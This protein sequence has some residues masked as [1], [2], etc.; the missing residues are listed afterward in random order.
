MKPLRL[1]FESGDL[2]FW[3]A[4]G[5][6]FANQPVRGDRL[7]ASRVRPELV[8][9]GGDYWDGPYPVGHQG[10]Y[11][12]GTE[13]HLTGTLTSDEFVINENYP[14]FNF[15]IGGGHDS[16]HLRVELL[17]KATAENQLA[18]KAGPASAASYP[19][20]SLPGK[21]DFYRVFEATG[22]DSEVMRRVT[23][24]VVDTGLTNQSARI[25]IVDNSTTHHINTDDFNFSPDC[26]Q[27]AP[28]AEGGGDPSAPV[29]GIADLH[30]HPMAAL[31]LGGL[32]FW[33]QPDGP[34]ETALR[35]CTPAHGI[36]GTGLQPKKGGSN[37][38]IAF[39]EGT[40]YQPG[41]RNWLHPGHPVGGYPYFDGWPRFT[42]IIHQQ[43]SI[44]WLR[45]TYEG[46][47]RL[48]VAHVVNN[49]L[50]AHEF[51]S[52]QSKLSHNDKTAVE[53]QITAMK[54]LAARHA[55]WMEI[56]YSPAA[57][58]RII[59]QNK[60]AVVL[61][62]EVDSLGSWNREGDCTEDDVR[63]YL[64]HLYHDLGVR[65]LFPIH[66]AN[67]AF[68]GAAVYND[69]FNVINC[70]LRGDYFE[71]EDGS[72]RHVQFRLGADPGPAISLYQS[73]LANMTP[74]LEPHYAPPDYGKVPGGHVNVQGLTHLGRFLVKEMMRLGM[75]VDIDH[76]SYKA[77]DETL[78]IAERGDYPVVS[79]HTHF[80]ELAWQRQ[81]TA[82]IHKCSSEF[83][84]TKEQI[85]RIHGLGGMLAPILNQGDN[86]DVGDVLPELAGKVA[87]SCSGSA[88]SWAHAYLYAVEKMQGRGVGIGTD[89]NGF[90]K[91]PCP[92]FGM[93]ASYYLHY[94]I[95]GMGEDRQRQA[96]RKDQVELQTNGVCYYTPIVDAGRHR[97]EGVLAGEV[98]DDLE[99]DIWQ[100]LALYSAGL[101]PRTG[102]QPIPTLSNRVENL[103]K[104]FCATNDEQLLRPGIFNIGNGPW[105][106][107]A[108]FL[109]K[110]DQAPGHSERDP[111]TV[112]AIYSKILPIWRRWHAMQG[113]NT[114]LSR[115]RAGQRDFDI[116]IDGVAHYGMLP[117]FFQDLKNVGLTAEDLLPLFRSAEDYIQVW[118][119]CERRKGTTDGQS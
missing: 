74:H 106:Q 95:P 49:E 3:T 100:A 30:T 21:G 39:F 115:S 77:V 1:D 24:N 76:M 61:G 101:N 80:Q 81:E 2:A 15:L 29:W 51:G 109:V 26:P 66:L 19:I 69:L 65:H 5:E 40:G 116:N 93:N 89:M 28:L 111:E 20:I 53:V 85:E 64:H 4:E 102:E 48:M 59:R 16:A 105:E 84:R 38:L 56:A 58:R 99:R 92:R 72:A 13:N 91:S 36:A 110:T 10:D 82:S 9:L 46:G 83:F 45:R 108:A 118:E 62:V 6:A 112:H 73:P 27:V 12:I 31:A 57:A 43:M 94:N 50:L 14:W 42:T 86:R 52:E 23:F 96:L 22:S 63:T 7:K 103:A 78:E 119:T 88:T 54:A 11:W 8:P 107:R 34:I 44:D 55:G 113:S 35:D 97:F 98:Y 60:L 47:L 25:R 67:N 41:I 17:I 37:F 70:F 114:P 90:Y 18:A 71:V 68:G 104:G 75:L 33:G 117:D 79:G 87:K 32:I